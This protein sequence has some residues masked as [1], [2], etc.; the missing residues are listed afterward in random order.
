VAVQDAG[1][2]GM[3]ASASGELRCAWSRA[4]SIR[5]HYRRLAE[6]SAERWR[7]ATLSAERHAA[8]ERPVDRGPILAAERAYQAACRGAAR[9]GR[10]MRASA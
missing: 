7:Q 2:R 3:S 8:A 5:E 10:M 4:A 9:A 1:A 6:Q